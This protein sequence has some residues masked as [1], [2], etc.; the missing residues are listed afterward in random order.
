MFVNISSFILSFQ[1]YLDV[2]KKDMNSEN[3][4][5]KK[6]KDIIYHSEKI[7]MSVVDYITIS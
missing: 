6:K 1:I 3:E 5:K 2:K 7:R 4:K